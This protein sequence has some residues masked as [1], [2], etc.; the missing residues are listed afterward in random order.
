MAAA[1]EK[2]LEATGQ[3]PQGLAQKLTVP[4]S[5]FPFQR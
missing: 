5:Y 4:Q 3:L 1:E 2:R